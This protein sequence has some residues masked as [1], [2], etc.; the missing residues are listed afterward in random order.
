M[1]PPITWCRYG[2]FP[3]CRKWWCRNICFRQV[4]LGCEWPFLELQYRILAVAT[5]TP[6]VKMAFSW[7]AT[8]RC[9]GTKSFMLEKTVAWTFP[10]WKYEISMYENEMTFY[11]IVL[12]WCFRLRIWIALGMIFLLQKWSWDIGQCTISCMEFASTKNFRANFRFMH[13]N[14]IFFYYISH[15]DVVGLF[16]DMLSMGVCTYVCM[17]IDW[18]FTIKKHTR[19]GRTSGRLVQEVNSIL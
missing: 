18:N 5:R 17:F 1:A 12:K 7:Y 16:F 14:I 3:A 4:R 2:Q 19:N 8:C 11:F 9:P 6:I 15:N 10:P 13:S